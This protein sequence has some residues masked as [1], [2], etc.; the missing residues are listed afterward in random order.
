MVAFVL[1]AASVHATITARNAQEDGGMS[2]C[3]FVRKDAS[4]T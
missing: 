2:L 1:S 3:K 4:Q